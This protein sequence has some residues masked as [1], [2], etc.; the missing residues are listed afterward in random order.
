MRRI[1]IMVTVVVVL[2]VP[3]LVAAESDIPNLMGKWVGKARGIKYGKADPMAHKKES[4]LGKVTSLGFVITI[5]FQDGRA[6]SGTRATTRNSERLL[7]VIRSDNKTLY[8]VDE[9]GYL[10]GHLLS[11]N[12][13]EVIYREIHYPIH[14]L[15]IGIFERKPQ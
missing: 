13:M 15:S 7:G 1:I 3:A 11:E 4:E 5:D 10:S 12:K 6:F 9:D 8:M 2:I 14:G